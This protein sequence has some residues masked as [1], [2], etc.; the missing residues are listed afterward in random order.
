MSIRLT[1]AAMERVAHLLEQ[2]NVCGVRIRL[3]TRGCS[4]LS[5]VMEYV[6]EPQGTDE[7]IPLSEGKTLF[8]HNKALLFLVGT[9]M[10]YQETPTRSGFIFRNPNEK[11]QCGCGS[12]FHV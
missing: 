1:P 12:S 5:Y 10:D 3:R 8:I 9:E 6:E 7:A 2:R 11:G 4:G